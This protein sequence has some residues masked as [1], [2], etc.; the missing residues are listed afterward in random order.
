MK[1]KIGKSKFRDPE[2]AQILIL[3]SILLLLLVYLIVKQIWNELMATKKKEKEINN[4]KNTC[5]P[6]FGNCQINQ[7]ASVVNVY[8]SLSSQKKMKVYM[9]AFRRQLKKTHVRIMS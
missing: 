9:Y 5:M 2:N 8:I 7:V 1:K 3:K 6:L 4:Y